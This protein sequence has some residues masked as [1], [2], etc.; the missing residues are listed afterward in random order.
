MRLG[1][2]QSKVDSF[3]FVYHHNGTMAYTFY[4]T[5]ILSASST[6]LLQQV[7]TRLHDAFAIK[8]MGPIRHFLGITVRYNKEGSFSSKLP[9]PSAGPRI[10]RAL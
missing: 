5:S 1:F 2:V 7:I 8:D 4:Y 3:F 6:T 10:L 9:M